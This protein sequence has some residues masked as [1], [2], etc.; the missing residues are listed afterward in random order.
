M[1]SRTPPTFFICSCGDKY[2]VSRFNMPDTLCP[3]CREREKDEPL[4][5]PMRFDDSP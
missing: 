4:Y 3:K 2:F 5:P 1:K